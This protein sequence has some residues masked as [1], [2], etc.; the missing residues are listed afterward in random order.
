MRRLDSDRPQPEKPL[1]LAIR[2]LI[3]PLALLLPGA[4][5][6]Q[7]QIPIN[8]A[9]VELARSRACVGPLA[10]LQELEASLEPFVQ[11]VDRLNRLGRAVTLEK[12]QDVDPLDDNDPI[13]ALVGRWFAAD[14]TLAVRFLEEGDSTV[15]V[16]RSNAR[17]EILLSLRQSVQEVQSEAQ[18]TMGDGTAVRAAAEPCVGAILIR[19]A[20]LE[21]CGGES[22][23]VCEAAASEER[24]GTYIFVEAP[25]DLWGVEEYGPW[26][27]PVPIQLGPTGE[28]I[29][30][31]TSARVRLG[32]VAIQ[33]TLKPLLR[34]RSDLSDEEN[35]Q[36]RTN[37]DSLGYSF[38]HPSFAMAPGFDLQGTL[39]PPLGGETHYLLHF[40]DLSGDDIIWT[41]EA[42]EGGPIRAVLPARAA[43]L[44][45]LQAGELVSLTAIR[46]P[47][48]EGGEGEALYTLSLL[49]VGQ[50]T[51]VGMLLEYLRDGGFDRDLKALFPPGIGGEPSSSG[52]P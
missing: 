36:Y 31:S 32:N 9:E 41:M 7:D 40:S 1:R 52:C 17:T 46:A 3:T 33:V 27:Q 34:N 23:P 50:P 37:L 12:R 45:R 49:Q 2:S 10:D 6:A 42:G 25:A 35:A 18:A 11:R 19:S 20:V 29:G 24:Q 13:E 16:E 47:E 30:A 48:Q 43:D 51:N 22:T 4:L 5:A 44:A 39:P 14:S 8:L 21:A 26:D 38:D 15:L 28:L